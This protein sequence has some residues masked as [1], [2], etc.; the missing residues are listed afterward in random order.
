[1]HLYVWNK[2]GGALILTVHP[3]MGLA[4]KHV[5]AKPCVKGTEGDARHIYTGYFMC[6][7]PENDLS[8]ED[9]DMDEHAIEYISV[10]WEQ[11]EETILEAVVRNHDIR[12]RKCSS[13]RNESRGMRLFNRDV[14]EGKESTDKHRYNCPHEPQPSNP[15]RTV[16]KVRHKDVRRPTVNEVVNVGPKF[17]R[18]LVRL[19]NL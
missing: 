10:T 16:K 17:T 4:H 19:L 8:V 11:G 3:E 13:I 12:P 5:V 2:E 7:T 18:I 1:V 15:S 9:D 14:A 6:P